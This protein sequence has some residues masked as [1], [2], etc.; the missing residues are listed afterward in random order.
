MTLK[1]V[2]AALGVALCGFVAKAETP[3]TPIGNSLALSGSIELT[4]NC[5]WRGLDLEIAENTTIDLKGH[6]LDLSATQLDDASSVTITDTAAYDILTY[7]QSTGTQWINTGLTPEWDD[8]IETKVHFNDCSGNQAIWCSRALVDKVLRKQFTAMNLAAKLRFDHGDG[9]GGQVSNVYGV[10]SQND[11]TIVA[12]GY[13]RDV[14]IN[15]VV[16]SKKMAEGITADYSCPLTLFVAQDGDPY[17]GKSSYGRF[18]CY[19]FK[20]YASD[21]TLKLDLVPARRMG[22]KAVGM[23]DRV[24]NVFFENQGDGVFT[25]GETLQNGVV[26]ELHMEVPAGVTATGGANA[27]SGGFMLVKEG[28]GTF[29]PNGKLN[30]LGG[31]RIDGGTFQMMKAGTDPDAPKGEIMVGRGATLD[32]NGKCDFFKNTI[33]LA[34]GTLQNTG[35]S[36]DANHAQLGNVR[37][38]GNSTM[39]IDSSYGF[40]GSGYNATTLDLGGYELTVDVAADKNFWFD[41]VGVAAGKL[42]VTGEGTFAIDKTSLRGAAADFDL[43]CSNVTAAVNCDV[44]GW[45]VGANTVVGGSGTVTIHGTYRPL[46]D[47]VSKYVLAEGA[48]LDLS[49]RS[50]AFDITGK[51]VAFT[52]GSDFKVDVGERKLES[53]DQLMSWSVIPTGVSFSLVTPLTDSDN[54]LA[55]DEGLYYFTAPAY[56]TIDPSSGTWSFFTANGAPYPDWN[57]GVTPDIE[58][59][60]SSKAEYDAIASAGVTPSRYVLTGLEM[61]DD[62]DL[63]QGFAFGGAVDTTI[64]LR[65]HKLHLP[66]G[67]LENSTHLTITD[68]GATGY[69]ILTYIQSTGTQ[70]INTG[71]TPNWD[72]RIE[73]KVNFNNCTGNQTIWC[74]RTV[75]GAES[76]TALNLNAYLRFDHDGQGTTGSKVASGVD[77]SIVA[78]GST[79]DVTINGSAYSKKLPSGTRIS[80]PLALFVS[81]DGDPENSWINAGKFKCY[82]F[83]I[84]ASDGTLKLDLV[85]ARRLSDGAVGMLD[86]VLSVFYPNKGSGVDFTAGDVV[87]SVGTTGELHVN[88][89]AGATASVGQN[90]LTGGLRLVKDGEGVLVSAGTLTYWGGTQIDSGTIQLGMD[91]AVIGVRGGTITVASDG[92]LEVNGK[93]DFFRNVIALAGGTL[94]NTTGVDISSMV[95]QLAN[96]RLTA[97]S[98]MRIVNS[99]GLI[100]SGYNATT[101]DL[102]GYELTVDVAADKSFWLDNVDVTAGKLKVTGAGTFAIDKTSLRGAAADFDLGCS[103]VTAAVNC[104]VGDWTV[105]ANTVVGGSGTVTI[106]GTYRPL[107]DSVSKYVLAEGATLDLS[108]RST[109]FDITGKGVA[110]TAGTDFKVDVGERKL[111]SGDQLMS[112]SVIPTGVSFS[113]ANPLSDADNLQVKGEGLYYFTAPAYATIDPSS[114]TWSFF[115]ANGAPYP[116]W[117]DGVT[118]DIEVRFAS[119]SEYDAIL[120]AGV[121]PSRY[122]LTGLELAEDADLARGFDFISATDV[123]IDLKGHQ[124]HLPSKTLTDSPSLTITDTGSTG[125]DI[126]TYIQSTGTQ[127]INTGLTPNWDD[128]IETKVHFNDCTGN[129]AIWCARTNIANRAAKQ[130]TAMNLS[131]YLRFDHANGQ[132][133]NVHRVNSQDDFTIVADG[134]TRDVTINGTV[135]SKKLTDGKDAEISGPLTLFVA[136]DGAPEKAL[137]SPGRF[138]CYYFKTYAADGTLR[139]DLVPARRM[140]DGAVGMLDRV[141]KVFF[142]NQGGVDFTAGDV[143]KSVGDIGELHVNVPTDV[144]AS[145]GQHAITGRLKLV[146]DGNGKLLADGTLTHL[147]D[148]LIDGGTL[149]LTKAGGYIGTKGGEITVGPGATFEM[150]GKYDFFQNMIILAGG[151]L[152]NTG[153]DITGSNA[154]LA[155]VRLTANSTMNVASSFGLINSGYNA[156]TLDLGGYELAVNVARD[157]SFWFDNVDVTAG[158]LKVAGEGTFAIDKTSLRGAAADF[159]LECGEVTVAVNCDVGGWTVGA[160]T[161][162]SGSGTVTIRDTYRPLGDSVSNYV[163]ADR[164]TFD[165]S[166]RSTAFDITDKNLS[167]ADGA[168]IFVNPLPRKG[169]LIVPWTTPS[170]LSTLTF[171]KTP[172]AEGCLS[173]DARGIFFRRGLTIM[174][175]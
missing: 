82:F 66:G 78:N 33:I 58:V 25:A 131:A 112:W 93:N 153:T 76:F 37:L 136:H 139:L 23:L 152:Q 144:T 11:F 163:L 132:V 107:G 154:Q 50:T 35:D 32:M 130:F 161:A 80:G 3:T 160:N 121:T 31:T 16:C 90:T 48:T 99:F 125:Y 62:L 134:Y 43:G 1:T 7:I 175:R 159:D 105:G 18:K 119:K 67:T 147:G 64:D 9:T 169:G 95:T 111:E 126:L 108:S 88:V 170:N 172:D 70:W 104:D 74:S 14:T 151:T 106:H 40:I 114:G 157:K 39:R 166:G 142:E 2:F 162:V 72:D 115:T 122:V 89:P 55:K 63:S 75:G 49:G 118:P 61:T 34:G 51:G 94:Q 158:K 26:G 141:T 164:A 92:T 145:I 79:C 117:K 100:N 173:V 42:K 109:A 19:Y 150:N 10:N 28:E 30:Y 86:R 103:N 127:W 168:T 24:T 69:D 146:K 98:T 56:A 8:R 5:D 59:R 116:D 165:L 83:K 68:T 54:L 29:A 167:F 124:L 45:T 17:G 143:V 53:G 97:N 21:G 77:Y 27:F 73:T 6:K 4:E 57:G 44:G 155:N 15:G 87:E 12:D 20:I 140:S 52:A 113:L 129:Q 174:I 128:R 137:G 149:Q 101:L 91:G 38:T 120:S 85:P 13:T 81:H 102:G 22:D 41:N 156:T 133:S 135:Y 46:G 71:L 96:V 36:I 171:R 123:T 47:S 65:G 110:F 148:T 84:Y 60:F 138:K